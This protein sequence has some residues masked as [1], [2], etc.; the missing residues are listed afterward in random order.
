MSLT[1]NLYYKGT[2]GSARAFAEEMEKSGIASRLSIA[3]ARIA[4]QSTSPLPQVAT[5]R[6]KLNWSL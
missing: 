2:N 4:E 3:P 5:Q 6:M 1:V